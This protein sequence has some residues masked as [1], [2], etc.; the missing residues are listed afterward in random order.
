[1]TT[2]KWDRHAIRA[3]VHRRGLTLTG[4]AKKAGLADSSCRQGLLGISRPGA[5]AIAD[6]LGIPFRTL[7]PDQYS[8]G[9]E[10]ET[11]TDLNGRS[12]AS[13]KARPAADGK[14]AAA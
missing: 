1:M 5:Q 6:A 8:R 11:E 4:I 14:A 12:K 9:R 2:Q 10:S 7:F 3:E 13:A